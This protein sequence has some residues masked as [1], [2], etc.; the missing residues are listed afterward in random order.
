MKKVF[1]SGCYDIVHGG[2]VEFFKQAK[3]LGDYLI[4]SFASDEVLLKYK[5]RISALPEK[6]KKFLLENL[7]SVDKV[8]SSTNSEDPIFD[9]RDA[10]IKEKADILV[11][12]EDDRYAKEKKKFCEEHNAEYVQLPKTLGFEQIS[13]SDLRDK[14][15]AKTQVPLRVDFAGGWLDVPKYSIPGA[16]IVNCAITPKV[17]LLDW[18]YKQNSGLGGSGAYWQLIE[19]TQ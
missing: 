16:Y 14:I 18:P 2:H 4:V 9:F 3:E 10:F 12:T 11:S 19:K 1:V 6:H 5:K 17:S 13:T 8:Y 15:S 7:K